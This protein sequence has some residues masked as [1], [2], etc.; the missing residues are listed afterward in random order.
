MLDQFAR[1]LEPI[2]GHEVLKENP[3]TFEE[4]CVLSEQI[5][6]IAK[7]AGGGGTCSKLHEPPD[8][9]PMELDSMGAH[10]HHRYPNK[11]IKNN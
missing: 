5:S 3:H 8:Y 4:A 9:I 1:G 11:G 6:R 10:W 7:L 2:I